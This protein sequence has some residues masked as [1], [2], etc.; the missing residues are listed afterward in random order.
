MKIRQL[1]S[2]LAAVAAMPWDDIRTLARLCAGCERCQRACARKL[3]TCDLLAEARSRNPHW[4]QAVWDLWIRRVGP[5]WP[6]FGAGY[7]TVSEQL[8][9]AFAVGIFA[10]LAWAATALVWFPVIGLI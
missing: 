2:L 1:F 6:M 8:K 7:Y 4:T 9:A 5:L 3:S 10:W